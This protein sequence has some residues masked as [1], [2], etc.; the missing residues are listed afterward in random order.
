MDQ[1]VARRKKIQLRA[2]VTQFQGVGVEVIRRHF[3]YEGAGQRFQAF[4]ILVEVARE[5]KF[6][7]L[8]GLDGC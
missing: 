3:E 6:K 7:F 5:E 4:G 8:R 1:E 2:F